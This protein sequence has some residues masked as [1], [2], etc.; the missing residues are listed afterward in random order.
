M[1]SGRILI[2]DDDPK[3]G[4]LIGELAGELGFE[5][6]SA[7]DQTTFKKEYGE[8]APTV[9]F[10]DLHMPDADG[11]Q[12]LNYLHAESCKA[13]IFMI[14]GVDRR[15]LKSARDFGISKG[16]NVRDA[17]SKPIDLDVLEQVLVSVKRPS[18]AI[19]ADEIRTGIAQGEFFPRYQPKLT[20]VGNGTG[21]IDS[22]EALV[23]WK[24]PSRG[25]L[26]PGLF[27]QS[28]EAEGMMA[29]M[30][31]SMVVSI[32]EQMGKWAADDIKPVVAFNLSPSLLNDVTLPDRYER[33][34][35][36]AGLDPDSLT[37][38]ITESAVMADVTSTAEI[39]TRFRIKGF[40]LSIDDFGT[41][42]S[43]LVELYR[44]PFNELKVDQAFVGPA[45]G[46]KE[47][48]VIVSLLVRLAHDLGMSACAEGA[49]DDATLTYLRDLGCEKA[50]GYIV[51][52]PLTA[53]EFAARFGKSVD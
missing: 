36:D 17:L 31:D 50:Q 20:L 5:A 10:V 9:L 11:I 18:D 44:M 15:V 14:S 8:F 2:V 13:E 29:E 4:E 27:L 26:L 30:T 12:T 24:H 38:E 22:A 35:Y 7:T 42:Y 41:G 45:P 53:E 46:D 52:R 40:G 39:L 51:D 37:I 16:L 47:A 48:A 43:S 23:R 28:V 3:M 32:A 25:E 33:I 21:V 6:R 1:T 49:E 34:V 19:S